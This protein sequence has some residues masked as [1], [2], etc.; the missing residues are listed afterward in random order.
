MIE[1]EKAERRRVIEN[2]KAID[3]ANTARREWL[4]TFLTAKIP[5]K[6]TA[7]LLAEALADSGYILST[8]ING[9]RKMLDELLYPGKAKRAGMKRVP[10]R[11]N[12]GRYAVISSPP[13]PPRTRA[14][15]AEAR[16]GWPTQE[17]RTGC[18]GA[19]PTASNSAR[20]NSSSSTP[21]TGAQSSMLTSRPPY[22]S[23]R[24]VRARPRRTPSNAA[25]PSTARLGSKRMRLSVR[26][27]SSDPVGRGQPGFGPAGPRRTDA[28]SGSIL[29]TMLYVSGNLNQRRQDR[30]HERAVSQG[31]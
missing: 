3:I 17:S 23:P 22:R 4:T 9:G 11:G 6:G 27:P 15:S 12:D 20:S 30:P 31:E 28:I 14:A 2:K 29:T 5:P 26:L 10:A 1:Q 19:S 7:K 21:S 18:G 16:G 13:S 8:W 25:R 24:R